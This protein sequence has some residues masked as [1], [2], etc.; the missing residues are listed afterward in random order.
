[1]RRAPRVA[2]AALLAAASA[3]TGACAGDDA[4]AGTTGTGLPSGPQGSGAPAVTA[5]E[6]LKILRDWT[7]R[8]NRAITSGDERLWRAAV[9]GGLAAPVS[10]RVRTYGRLP[11]SATISL[12]NPVLYVPRQ[13]GYPRWFGV[14][15]LERSNGKDRQVL[16]VFVKTTA[17]DGWRAAHWLT[18][19]GRPPELAYDP[20]GYAI[21]A[22]DRG[23]PAWHASY[24]ASGDERGLV[25]DAYSAAARTRR[26]G[27]WTAAPGRFAPGPGPSH[28]LRTKD[29]GSLV[30]YGL[31]QVQTLRGGTGPTLP[32]ELRNFLAKNHMEPGRSVQASWQWLAIGYAPASGMGRVLGESVS[33]TAA[34]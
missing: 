15:A 19:K 31:T 28:A 24:L 30:W 29:G 2:L 33:L 17:K 6:S 3:L 1:M 5:G 20:Q 11:E 32:G 4:G 16:G 14:A 25:P 12:L 23:L 7:N 10:A 34:R 27:D 21:P 13:N 18:F 22:P 26:Q 8:H 9:I